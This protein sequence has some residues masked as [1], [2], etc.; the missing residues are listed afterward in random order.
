MAPA[1]LELPISISALLIP[2]NSSF[3]GSKD[4]QDGSLT[5]ER[6]KRGPAV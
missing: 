6:R 1:S 5:I 3:E 2:N 4:M